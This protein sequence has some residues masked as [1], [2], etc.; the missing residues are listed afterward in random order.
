MRVFPSCFFL[1]FSSLRF[2]GLALLVLTLT[3]ESS[4]AQRGGEESTNLSASV[5]DD[6]DGDGV[7]S[8]SEQGISGATVSLLRLNL[9]SG[10]REV[11][12]SA[13]TEAN[14]RFTLSKIALGSYS[15]RYDFP[16]G[17]SIQ[18]QE[19]AGA[20]EGVVT[21]DPLTRES[22]EFELDGVS[23]PL[24]RASAKVSSGIRGSVFADNG[25]GIRGERGRRRRRK[26]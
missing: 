23:T 21:F 8:E 14:G 5:F 7:K 10:T 3:A 2:L 1:L 4:L 20:V 17:R 9:E 16:A 22:T 11:V 6:L 15:L 12:Q 26:A 25:D 18:L 13:K 24:I 19:V